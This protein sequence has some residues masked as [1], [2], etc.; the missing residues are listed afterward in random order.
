MKLPRFAFG[1]ILSFAVFLAAPAIAQWFQSLPRFWA[2]ADA[3]ALSILSIVVA[4]VIIGQHVVEHPLGVLINER[5]VMSLTRFQT[6]LW[7]VLITAAFSTL[8]LGAIY[9]QQDASKLLA[10]G[11]RPDL[12]ALMGISY[13]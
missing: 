6:V 5:N 7:T 11:L 3:Y 8:L 4:L 10:D 2:Y 9:S 13:A 12:L 1:L